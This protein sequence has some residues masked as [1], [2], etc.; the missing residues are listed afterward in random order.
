MQYKEGR[1]IV[2]AVEGE[3]VLVKSVLHFC[4]HFY[5]ELCMKGAYPPERQKKE[6]NLIISSDYTNKDINDFFWLFSIS[7]NGGVM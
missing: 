7:K 4:N 2:E 1:G 5:K 3:H 6:D